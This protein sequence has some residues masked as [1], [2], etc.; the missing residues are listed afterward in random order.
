ML[1]RD[2]VVDAPTPKFRN[3][4]VLAAT[5]VRRRRCIQASARDAIPRS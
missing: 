2:G 5:W 4:S 1:M 3:R